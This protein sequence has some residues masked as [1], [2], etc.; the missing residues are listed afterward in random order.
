MV[1]RVE[2]EALLPRASESHV[3]CS[4]A[5]CSDKAGKSGKTGRPP[6]T[7][8][9]DPRVQQLKEFESVEGQSDIF[10]IYCIT[11]ES[12]ETGALHFLVASR[13]QGLE[14]RY[15]A[16]P[17]DEFVMQRLKELDDQKLQSTTDDD[18]D[19]KEKVLISSRMADSPCVLATSGYEWS[20]D[21]GR[22][23]KAQGFIW[24]LIWLLFDT[25]L[26]ALSDGSMNSYMYSLGSHWQP[27][28]AVADGATVADRA[29]PGC[30]RAGL[31]GLSPQRWTRCA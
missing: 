2:G 14:V 4:S 27:D 3:V 15:M 29:F 1:Q 20:A 17:I 9:G 24:L 31:S 12:I 5:L 28:G 13:R 23:M 26:L 8:E 30:S 18:E 19:E 21:I 10:D 6:A 25:F 22:T 11:D 16:D 7:V